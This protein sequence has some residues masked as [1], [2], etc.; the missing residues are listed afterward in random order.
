M[1]RAHTGRMFEEHRVEPRQPIEAPLRM[2]GTEAIA[3]NIS[4]SGMYVEIR[5]DRPVDGTVIIEMEWPEEHLRFRAQGRI[6]RM[7]HRDGLT[8]IALKLE[9]PQLEPL[10]G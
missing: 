4:P 2:D 9:S 7:E 3:R 6:V 5:G 10:E 8:G 1:R